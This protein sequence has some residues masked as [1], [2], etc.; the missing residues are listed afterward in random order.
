VE[1]VVV[2]I[3]QPEALEVLTKLEGARW[4]LSQEARPD[5]PYGFFFWLRAWNAKL[6]AGLQDVPVSLCQF[7]ARATRAPILY[8]EEGYRRYYVNTTGEL[9]LMS[10]SALPDA[11]SKA[12]L[13]GIR[14]M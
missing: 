12:H 10:D 9:A 5:A 3:T 8:G 2:H 13:L 1:V 11:V 4:R 6:E 14:M 7:G